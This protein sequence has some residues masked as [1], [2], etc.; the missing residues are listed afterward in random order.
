M[1][2]ELAAALEEQYPA[3]SFGQSGEELYLYE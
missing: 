2:D 3:C 1:L